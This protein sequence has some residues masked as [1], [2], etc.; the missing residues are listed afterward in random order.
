MSLSPRG[1]LRWYASCCRTPIANT[2]RDAKLPYAGLVHTALEQ[3]QPLEPGFP[4]VQMDVNRG[5][6]LGAAPKR[7]GPLAMLKF[8]AMVLRLAAGRFT[9][10]WRSSPFFDAN[11]KPVAAVHVPPKAEVDAARQAAR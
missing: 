2:P 1:L 9:S 5:G 6:A 8:G 7:G 4:P 11:G 10:S 3:D